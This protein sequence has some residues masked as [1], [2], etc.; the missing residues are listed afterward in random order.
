MSTDPFVGLVSL[1]SLQLCSCHIFGF[2]SFKITGPQ[3][4][5]LAIIRNN[6]FD[7][8]VEISAPRLRFF[9]FQ[10]QALLKM[11]SSLDFPLL[12]MAEIGTPIGFSPSIPI[13]SL[14]I[15]FL[16]MI[17]VFHGLNHVRSLVLSASIIEGLINCPGVLEDQAS[18]FVRLKTLKVKYPRNSR[19][20]FNILPDNV[21]EYFGGNVK[22]EKIYE[23]F[24]VFSA[25]YERR[26]LDLGNIV[27]SEHCGIVNPT[28]ALSQ[29]NLRLQE[30]I[31]QPSE[32]YQESQN[33]LAELEAR[34]EIVST[35]AQHNIHIQL[36]GMPGH[37]SESSKTVRQLIGL[38]GGLEYG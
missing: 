1:K 19:N 5:S 17:N 26:Q 34:M 2:K 32:L 20:S 27:G 33:R 6:V 3:L 8:K 14:K 11:F 31:R 18:P 36:P 30:T 23:V 37:A 12:E 38:L 28:A 4:D 7:C 9:S 15:S 22:V 21:M 16:H 25:N 29:Q 13:E 24:A 35:L 10:S